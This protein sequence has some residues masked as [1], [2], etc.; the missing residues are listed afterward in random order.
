MLTLSP[1]APRRGLLSLWLCLLLAVGLNISAL[2]Q[3][4]PATPAESLLSTATVLHSFTIQNFQTTNNVDGITFP[5]PLVLGSDGSFYG[6]AQSGGPNGSG[7]VFKVTRTGILTVLF[8]FESGNVNSTGAAPNGAL[9]ED[10]NAPGTF[11][12]VTKTG[13]DNASGTLF[14]LVTT[15]TITETVLHSFGDPATAN[16]GIVPAGS[17]ALSG[18]VLYG[19]AAGGGAHG[20]AG[21]LYS[22]HTD[23]T[24]YS[25]LHSFTSATDGSNPRG[26]VLGSALYGVAPF[27]GAN[28]AGTVWTVATDGTGFHTL[29]SFGGADGYSKPIT[30]VVLAAD[31][32]LYGSFGSGTPD[33]YGGI[34]KINPLG[35]LSVLHAFVYD[36]NSGVFEGGW[37]G[38][39]TLGSDGNVYGPLGQV[40]FNTPNNAFNPSSDHRHFEINA[41]DGTLTLLANSTTRTFQGYGETALCAAPD[42][43]FYGL[44]DFAGATGYGDVFQLRPAPTHVLTVSSTG[45]NAADPTTLRGAISAAQFGDAI[46]FSPALQAAQSTIRLT[47]GELFIS[48]D[49][50]VAYAPTQY[51][52]TGV[53]GS[54]T[55]D[56]GGQSRI[57]HVSGGV[58]DV[59]G[60]A[61]TNGLVQGQSA[62]AMRP[63]GQPGPDVPNTTQGGGILIDG[64]AAVLLAGV[65]ITKC[66]V[67]TSSGEGGGLCLASGDVTFNGG[68]VTGCSA[69]TGGGMAVDTG[70]FVD[71]SS[72]PGGALLTFTTLDSNQ[73]M[74]GGGFAI[75]GSGPVGLFF[76]TV[77]HNQAGDNG[78][79]FYSSGGATVIDNSTFANNGANADLV[80]PFVSSGSGAGGAVYIAGGLSNLDSDTFSSNSA[81][82]G[83]A[84]DISTDPIAGAG[85]AKI[86][87]T[88]FSGNAAVGSAGG[89]NP[90]GPLNGDGGAITVDGGSLDLLQSTIGGL[91]SLQTAGNHADADGGGIYVGTGTATINDITFYGNVAAGRGGAVFNST[92]GTSTSLYYCTVTNNDAIAGGGLYQDYDDASGGANVF[93][94]YSAILA[95][96]T[97]SGSSAPVAGQDAAVT[98]G[99][100]FTTNGSN[101]LG[102]GAGAT[103]LDDNGVN[104]DQVGNLN[105]SP[106]LDPLLFPLGNYGGSTL[107]RALE[108]GSPALGM[109]FNIDESL[110]KY[111]QRGVQRPYPNPYDIGAAEHPAPHVQNASYTTTENTALVTPAPGVLGLDY[112]DLNE[113]PNPYPLTA[114]VTTPPANGALTLNADGSFT[115]TPATGFIGTDSFAY[116]AYDTIATS[117]PATVTITVTGA[118]PTTTATLSGTLGSSGY[119]RSAVTVTL[120]ATD[121]NY[122]SNT[123]T[124]TYSVD[125]GP[126]QTYFAP[127][128]SGGPATGTGPFTVSGDGTHTVTFSS[129][130]PAGS[131]EALQTLTIKIDATPPTLTFGTP[132]PAPNAAGYNNAPVSIP[133]TA[134]DATSGVASAAPGSPVAFTAEGAKQTQVVTVTDA[135]GNSAQ[136]TTPA[137]N[138]DLTAPVTTAVTTAS[139]SGTL[140]TLTAIDNLSGVA[141]TVYSLDGNAA[142]P[143]T[144]PFTVQTSGP[145]TVT[146]HS[147]DNAG[148]VESDKTLSFPVA[149]S[150]LTVGVTLNTTSP[151][152]NDTLTATATAADSVGQPVTLT[153]VWR[154]GATVVKTTANT[155][156][157]SDTLDL[158]KP[159]NGDKGNVITVTVIGTDGTTTSTPAVATATVVNSPPAAAGVTAS[160]TSGVAVDISLS[161]T[162]ADQDSLTFAVVTAPT[163]GTVTITGVVAHYV[164]TGGYVG[165]DTFTFKAN[166]GQADSDAATVSLT[167]TALA[168]SDVTSLLTI[169]RSP[170]TLSG[171][172]LPILQGGQG[173]YTQ[174]VTLTNH[175]T[176]TIPGPLKLVLDGL[177]GGSLT[178]GTGTVPAP[179]G[180]SSP[181]VSVD[182]GGGLAPGQTVSV[183]LTF[184]TR[185]PNSVSYAAR[186][187]AGHGT[188]SPAASAQVL[189]TFPAGMQMLSVTRDYRSV[190]LRAALSDDSHLMA[191][192]D[193]VQGQYGMH[194]DLHPGGGY[195]VRF[196]QS[197]DLYDAGVPMPSDK[198]C[199]IALQSGWNMI[200]DPFPTAVSVAG[201]QVQDGGGAQSSF[202]Q[203]V[204]SGL[205]GG[206]L[207]AYP[208]GASQYQ[209]IGVDGSL[210]PFAGE[211]IY[212]YRPCTLLVSS[213]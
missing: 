202:S 35:A 97:L 181:Y 185:H 164:P 41:S 138:L 209:V 158:S 174:K 31:G 195:W 183:T 178:N 103:G 26:L 88:T 44:E 119:Y 37:P 146:Y 7:T 108:P 85:Y 153:Y 175:S 58:V 159:G 115:Y 180:G 137:V 36:F 56:A 127:G 160:T 22:I 54:L 47:Q 117:V 149:V 2:A 121:P 125:G 94:V 165:P 33:G 60:L 147:T 136:F 142:Q 177:T 87:F 123:L 64:S 130:D 106:V 179:G 18:G 154:N 124:T 68:M 100:T 77:S 166:D 72:L 5:A 75:Q 53:S 203:A 17:L 128:S 40:P 114:T 42:G 74:E 32:T 173:K 131:S 51:P 212:A 34:Y 92:A 23:G 80:N 126:Q 28:S 210:S 3:S 82:T 43:T 145:H 10:P 96:N 6:V 110:N 192:W 170:L 95:Q 50:N 120:A 12:G 157:L 133:Y 62:E 1:I 150:T 25:I 79:G 204:S 69:P 161:G 156:S 86:Y 189:H 171:P 105:G 197:T 129:A 163:H 89:A 81:S 199:A 16:D 139:S 11:Y 151:K 38:P 20:N 187:L 9:I 167:V 49:L 143:Y 176:G 205:L 122:A 67:A 84:L 188:T 148:N 193:P 101:L 70:Q 206:T 162:D 140:V 196:S 73:A 19:T 135:A 55:I 208:T 27:G 168:D 112:A 63:R 13:G 116:T 107:T 90:A 184:L 21:A 83:G 4:S 66:A 39:V 190:G 57:F 93:T 46:V 104:H 71:G 144:A 155:S 24:G 61:L 111:D 102:N 8:V 91:A 99:G 213:P 15:G 65:S 52:A 113:N 59:S 201:L 141:G 182:V 45:D 30:S 186:V 207:Y 76:G 211:W 29:Y 172:Y 109:S 134:A 152:T 132:V 14:K 48:Q 198:P 98:P 118:V 194:T 78:G 191:V 200:G 169:V